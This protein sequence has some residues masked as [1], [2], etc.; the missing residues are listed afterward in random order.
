MIRLQIK[1]AG[2]ITDQETSRVQSSLLSW[3]MVTLITIVDGFYT[4]SL[5]Y[6]ILLIVNQCW[7]L[8]VNDTA[9]SLTWCSMFL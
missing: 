1:N 8:G 6:G 5:F 2:M 4:G 9:Y 7:H 3:N